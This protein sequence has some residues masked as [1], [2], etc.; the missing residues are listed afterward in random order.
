[1]Q[2]NGYQKSVWFL[3]PFHDSLIDNRRM[4]NHQHHNP[5]KFVST[6]TFMLEKRKKLE[7]SRG[8]IAYFEDFRFMVELVRSRYLGL[9]M[10]PFI[11]IKSQ[12]MHTYELIEAKIFMGATK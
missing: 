4:I 7:Y 12:V 8:F 1:M 6:L 5:Q 10:F 3:L 9:F 11:R 2:V